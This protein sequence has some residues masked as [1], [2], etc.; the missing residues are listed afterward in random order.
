MAIALAILDAA[1]HVQGPSGQRVIPWGEFFRLPGDTPEIDN[2]LQPDELIL[3]I[4]LPPSPFAGHS[5]Y[6]KVRDRH[7]YAF[8]LVSVAAGLEIKDGVIRR[9]GVGPGGSGSEALEGTRAE[10][11]LVGQRPSPEA[12]PCCCGTS[13]GG[14]DAS[15]AKRFQIRSW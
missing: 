2:T 8:A 11:S 6:L 10:D 5:W 4:E 14:C 12:F 15:C 7:S 13:N 9:A 1:V 3:V